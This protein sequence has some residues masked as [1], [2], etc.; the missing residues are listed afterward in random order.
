MTNSQTF[1][2]AGG[3]GPLVI[4][5]SN[6]A[7]SCF[8][9]KGAVIDIATCNK[10]DPNQ[11]F[12]FGT[13]G[14]AAAKVASKAPA[15]AVK[16]AAEVTSADST[17]S[18]SEAGATALACVASAAATSASS[19]ASAASSSISAPAAEAQVVTVT[20]TILDTGTST[21]TDSASSDSASIASAAAQALSASS[22]TAAASSTASSSRQVPTSIT[23]APSTASASA[24]AAILTYNPTTPLP[25]SRSGGSLNPGAAAEANQRD[26]T[27]ARAF[28]NVSIKAPNGA[29]LFIDPTAGD[30]RQ[31]T[32]PIALK[33]CDGSPNEKWDFLTSGKH[34]SGA[35]V[36]LVVSSL[37][38]GC[39]NVDDRR[40]V[41]DR[42]ILFSCGG[43]ADGSGGVTGSQVFSFTSANAT[44]KSLRL[45]AGQTCLV[46][47]ATLG[48]VDRADCSADATD[49]SQL[50]T[51]VE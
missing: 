1:P 50:F 32:I 10:A 46:A 49:A 15:K 37:V 25:V 42:V 14:K 21:P 44:A 18:L 33:P 23:S 24:A 20:V 22:T 38:Q 40:A 2:F 5:P 43:R 16:A 6:Q 27:A 47:N 19:S 45:Q 11:S 17:A 39:L 4:S 35:N 51:I 12:T 29:C 9:V 34:V 31:E 8:T 30:F 3:A 48:R 7:G 36:T 41:G 26:D 28:S 13:G